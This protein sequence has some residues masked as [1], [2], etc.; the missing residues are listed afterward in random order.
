VPLVDYML[1]RS[2][3]K[4][5]V[6]LNIGGIANITVLP[7]GAAMDQ[8]VAFDT[9]PGNMVI[10]QLVSALTGGKQTF[11]RDGRIAAESYYNRGLLDRLLKD[12]YYAA[13]PPK[14]AGREQYGRAF[15]AALAESG[16]PIPDL[17][18]TATVL[19]AATIAIGIDRFAPDT[20]E[21]IACGGG[22]HNTQLMVQIEAFLPGCRVTTTAQYGVD[23]DAREAIAFAVLAYRTWRRQPGNLPSATGARHSV[24][25]GKVTY[26]TK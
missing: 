14:T 4:S 26:G 23:P 8:V 5:R 11:D 22:V 21:V 9:G 16:H 15:V 3:A 19:T 13:R 7:R 17:I 18:A 12:P 10:D 20:A 2:A 1:F 25:L 24:L 6:I